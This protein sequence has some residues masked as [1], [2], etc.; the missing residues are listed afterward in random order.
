MSFLSYII[1]NEGLYLSI[2]LFIVFISGWLLKR[3]YS[4]LFFIFLKFRGKIGERKAEKLLKKNGFRIIKKQF[5]I[6]S[7]LQVNNETKFFNVKPDFLVKK[8]NEIFIAEVKTGDSASIKN[9]S[10]RR[11]LLEYSVINNSNRVILV[12]ISNQSISIINFFK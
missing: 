8:N 1:Q 3:V 11:Q 10:T 12:D 6:E 4:S 5:L 2:L 9:I 7:A